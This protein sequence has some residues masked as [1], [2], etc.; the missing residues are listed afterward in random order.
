M[1]VREYGQAPPSRL[2]VLGWSVLLMAVLWVLAGEVHRQL[3]PPRPV[4]IVVPQE[5]GARI[6]QWPELGAQEPSAPP[7]AAGPVGNGPVGNGP[8]GNGPVEKGPAA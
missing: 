1:L 6:Y 2:A 3:T 5:D 4:V 7:R 8:V